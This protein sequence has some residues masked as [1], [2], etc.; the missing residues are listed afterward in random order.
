MDS[1]YRRLILTLAAAM[2]LTGFG[3]ALQPAFAQS[4][5]FSDVSLKGAWVARFTGELM[6]LPI[7][8]PEY[9]GPF[10]RTGRFVADGRGNISVTAWANYAGHVQVDNYSGVYSVASDGTFTMTVY[11]LVLNFLDLNALPFPYNGNNEISFFGALED[12]GRAAKVMVTG[13]K[14]E[15]VDPVP[16]FGTIGSVISGEFHRQ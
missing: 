11:N 13:I 14:I 4:T 12:N 9:F 16:I 15:G 10:V 3:A 1:A 8:K 5:N 7:F 2:I 6:P